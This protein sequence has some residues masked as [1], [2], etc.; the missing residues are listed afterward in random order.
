MH[1][2]LDKLPIHKK[3]LC[4]N[5]L[6]ALVAGVLSA[7]LLIG[8]IWHIEHASAE[9]GASVQAAIIAENALPALQFRDPKTAAEILAGL[10]RDHE[11]L[12]AR[13]VEPNGAV[14]ARFM[15]LDADST[16]R[17][18]QDHLIRVAVPM[19]VGAERLATLELTHD[20][21][22]VVSQI[23]TYVGTV[24]LATLVALLV[25]SL[26]VARLQRAITNPL[27]DLTRLMTEV[28]CGGDLSRR[29]AVPGH[30]ELSQLSDSFNRI[31]EQIETRNA[32]LGKELAERLRAEKRLEHLAHHDQVTGLP[33]RHFFRQR[34]A[35]LMRGKALATGTMALLFVDLDNFKY[36]NDTFGHDCGDQLLVAVAD[37]LSG[38]VRAHDMVV[39]FGGDEFIV[40]LDRI[41]DTQQAVRLSQKLLAAITQPFWLAEREFFITCSIG[42]ALAPDH[43]NDF[44]ELLQKA[45]AAMYAAKN[46][47]KNG[48]RLWEPSISNDS[49]SRF[50]LESD[51][52]Q[53]LAHNELEMHYQPVVLLASGRIVGMEALM[54]WRHPVRGFISPVEFIPVAEDTGLILELGEWAMRTAFGQAAQW[55]TR[56]GPLFVAVN[57][58]GRQFRERDFAFK[59]DAIAKASNLPRGMCELEVTESVI[60]GQTG[61]AVRLLE[62]L[63][64]RGFSLSLDDFGT[65]YSSLSYL[66]RF[67]LNKLKIDRSFVK[68][69]PDDSEDAAIAEAIIGLAR[70]LTMRVVAEGIETNAQARMLHGLGCQYGQGYYFSKPLPIAQMDA[71]IAENME[72]TSV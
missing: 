24:C 8:V 9:A 32:A 72:T 36:I 58:S 66:K 42:V 22:Q 5:M 37:R 71:F 12:E 15:P 55:N 40:L 17:R 59:A 23:K 33:N 29:S 6:T 16:R 54:R 52:R 49:S 1:A 14:F 13:I 63:S 43:A 64:G 69:L 67:P 70:T 7:L 10:G 27:S 30:D 34:T 57:V 47:G 60:M 53:A 56:F 61:E 3:L 44:D 38:A 48:S 45:D 21:A 25:G 62:D 4:F 51:L 20:T 50:A 26:L 19:Q 31:I 35:D 68:D 18:A 46:A 2:W 11:I 65:G 39:R 28:S 41:G